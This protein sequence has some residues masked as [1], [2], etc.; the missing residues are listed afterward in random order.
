MTSTNKITLNDKAWNALFKKYNILSEIS[1]KGYCVISASQ[2]KEFREPRLMVKFDKLSYKPQIFDKEKLSILPI[3]RGKYIISDFNSHHKL[4]PPSNKYDFREFPSYIESVNPTNISSESVAL[5]TAD[6]MNILSHFI[7]DEMMV[8]TVSGRRSS[9]EF[10]FNIIR[11]KKDKLHIEVSNSQIEVDGAW[12][13]LNYLSLIE[14]KMDYP[15]DF[16]IRQ[17]YYPF[18]VF[19][20]IIEKPI[21]NIFLFYSNNQFSLYEY[22]FEDINCYHSLKLNKQCNYLI[23]D[24]EI[25]LEDITGIYE[26][27]NIQPE[28]NVP[29]PQANSFERVINLCEHLK[30]QKLTKEQIAEIYSFDNRQS[31]YY[32]NAGLYLGLIDKNRID[33]KIYYSLSKK[34]QQIFNMLFK[35]KQ[36]EL[37][38]CILRH[39]VFYKLFE[40]CTKNED[41]PDNNTVI[42][43]MEKCKLRIEK[44][45]IKRRASSV[46]AWIKWI[47]KLTDIEIDNF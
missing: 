1:N 8:P 38:K 7:D 3:T 28:P 16:I 46:L 32:T 18:R 15:D 47:F 6:S 5:N 25:F 12:E 39:E 9:G 42:E 43:Y 45:T 34:G 40:Y 22:V 36:L 13:G 2:I 44:E 19:N 21:K 17:L 29:F 11:N 10:D 37:V 20:K 14:A 27:V 31:D 30:N 33:G 26:S 41:L 35:E 23:Y 4:E 24:G